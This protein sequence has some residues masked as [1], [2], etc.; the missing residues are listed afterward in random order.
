MV[1]QA[2]SRASATSDGARRHIGLY[3]YRVGALLRLARLPPA[4]LE[5][6]EKL[7]QLR[8]PEHGLSICVAEARE[9]PGKDVNTLS[10]H[11]R[12]AALLAPGAD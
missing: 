3:S 12:A 1:P 10:Y 9:R 2:G 7:E 6:R 4:S 11:E 8:A 5:M